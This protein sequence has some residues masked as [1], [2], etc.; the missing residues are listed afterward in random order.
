MRWNLLVC[1]CSSPNDRWRSGSLEWAWKMAV[2]FNIVSYN[3]DLW[4]CELNIYFSF[5]HWFTHKHT[6]THTYLIILYKFNRP[7]HLTAQQLQKMKR[8]KKHS[9]THINTH[10]SSVCHRSC[11]RSNPRGST[12]QH[13]DAHVYLVFNDQCI[14]RLEIR[15]II[16]CL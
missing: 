10:I 8:K 6:P 15:E 11:H 7:A 1:V 3:P 9:N 2:K 4:Q 16:F 5:A 13:T 12:V 14:F